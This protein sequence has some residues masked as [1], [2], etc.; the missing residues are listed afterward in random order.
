M[1][2][3]KAREPLLLHKVTLRGPKFEHC[4]AAG[5]KK[6]KRLLAWLVPLAETPDITTMASSNLNHSIWTPAPP[7]STHSRALHWAHCHESQ[8]SS[9]PPGQRFAL[10]L[11]RQ[12]HIVANS[13]PACL[14]P[15]D[16]CTKVCTVGYRQVGLVCPSSGR[17]P[18]FLLSGPQHVQRYHKNQFFASGEQRRTNSFWVLYCQ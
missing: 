6:K 16:S 12:C 5:K 18:S 8:L 9:A 1:Q 3:L 17:D 11:P 14:D 15:S 4:S 7:H 2:P 10:M 13:V